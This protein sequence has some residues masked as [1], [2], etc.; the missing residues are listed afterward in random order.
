[1]QEV[2]TVNRKQ[3]LLNYDRPLTME[4]RAK[5]YEQIQTQTGCATCNSGYNTIQTAQEYI[6]TLQANLAPNPSFETD[7]TVNYWSVAVTGTTYSWATDAFKT[8]TRSLKIVSTQATTSMSRWTSKTNAIAATPGQTY[9]ASVW[10]QASGATQRGLLAINFWDSTQTY[11]GTTYESAAKV[12][13]TT[14]GFEQL[15]VNAVAP[16][17]TAYIR[18]EFRFYGPGTLWIDDVSLTT[19]PI[20]VTPCPTISMTPGDVLE[21]ANIVTGG[22]GP[23]N[24]KFQRNGIDIS[25]GTFAGVTEGAKQTFNYTILSTDAPTITLGTVI[26]DSCGT[27]QSCSK[28]CT[29]SVTG[30]PCP[31][32]SCDFVVT[33][34]G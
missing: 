19:T 6:Q 12:T 13:G 33:K 1:M 27:P 31:V 28:T 22:T 9:Y 24:V 34:I 26:T 4:D 5:V 17:N 15:S 21:L 14:A 10:M 25:G 8:G 29:V 32:P 20:V 30:V 2:V 18:L 3:F 11:L 23:Y 16:A 7:P